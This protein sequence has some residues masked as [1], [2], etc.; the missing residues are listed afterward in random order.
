MAV[1]PREEVAVSPWGD[2]RG[3]SRVARPFLLGEDERDAS[4]FASIALAGSR[5]EGGDVHGRG[6]P[7]SPRVAEGVS[8]RRFDVLA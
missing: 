8:D 3:E 7:A 1:W 4:K 2:E 5:V 6:G